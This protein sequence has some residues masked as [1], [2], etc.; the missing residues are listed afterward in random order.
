M[1]IWDDR[2]GPAIKH[3]VTVPLTCFN[4]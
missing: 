1:F 4:C 3:M 2:L